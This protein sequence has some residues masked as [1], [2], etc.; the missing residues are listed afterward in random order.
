VRHRVRAQSKPGFCSP[1]RYS[2][3]PATKEKN[4]DASKKKA[5]KVRI[6][7]LIKHVSLGNPVRGTE[8]LWDG[9]GNWH[10]R[11]ETDFCYECGLTLYRH[12]AHGVCVRCYGQLRQRDTEKQREAVKASQEKQNARRRE[13]TQWVKR[14]Q[15]GEITV[16][17]I[18]GNLMDNL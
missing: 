3:S 12:K 2:E 4:R 15:N 18:I 16:T 7:T 9:F 14:A 6:G 10:P 17:P 1:E 11:N 5:G 13:A 8:S